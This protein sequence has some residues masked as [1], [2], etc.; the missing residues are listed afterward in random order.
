MVV[1]RDA[2]NVWT[3]YSAGQQIGQ[4]TINNLNSALPTSYFGNPTPGPNYSLDT[5]EAFAFINFYGFGGTTFDKIV[6]SNSN[7]SGFEYDNA[8]SGWRPTGQTRMTYQPCPVC[9]WLTS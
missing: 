4:F 3:F 8:P 1:G 2:A 5:G 9:R 6:F 7:S